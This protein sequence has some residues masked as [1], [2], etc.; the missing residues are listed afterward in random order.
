MGNNELRNGT[1]R[2]RAVHFIKGPFSDQFTVNS[3]GI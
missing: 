1:I 2:L 3:L